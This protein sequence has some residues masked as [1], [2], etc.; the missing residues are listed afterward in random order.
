MT[1]PYKQ[2]QKTQV[3]TASREKILLMLY[4]GAIRFTKQ[5]RAAMNDKKIAD[6]GKAISKATAIISELMATLDFKVGG[7]LAQDLE[8][9]YIFMI[10]KLI[11]ANVYNKIECLDDVERLLNTLYS[12]WK[13]V[14]EHPRADGVPSPSLQ[15]DEFKKYQ[16]Q[17]IADGKELPD[18]K[19]QGD[20]DQGR[21]NLKIV[22]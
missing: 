7:Q 5:A 2:Y 3:V 16:E 19:R 17:L 13:D 4:E 18:S 1:N 10:D 12:A 9:L 14:I 6:K 8:N 22:A 21:G 11:E 15:P 20:K